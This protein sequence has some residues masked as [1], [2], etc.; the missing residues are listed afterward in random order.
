MHFPL[1]LL[2]LWSCGHISGGVGSPTEDHQVIGTAQPVVALTGQE[3]VLPCRLQPTLDA[4]R[5]TVEWSRPDLAPTYVH[6]LQDGRE[7]FGHKNPSYKFRTSLFAEELPNGNLSLRLSKATL[8]DQGLYKCFAPSLESHTLIQLLV[9]ATSQPVLTIIKSEDGQIVLMCEAKDLYPEPVMSWLD[10][11]GNF[12]SAGPTINSTHSDSCYNIQGN[13]TAPR[14]GPFTCRIQLQ[15]INYTLE[16]QI[17]LTES[18]FEPRRTEPVVIPVV[19]CC[20]VLILVVIGAVLLWYWKSQQTSNRSP[21]VTITMRERSN[22]I[23]EMEENQAELVYLVQENQNT[24]PV[25]DVVSEEEE[26]HGEQNA[27]GSAPDPTKP[28]LLIPLRR[29]KSLPI[30]ADLQ[31]SMSTLR[32]PS[33]RRCVSISMTAPIKISRRESNRNV[34]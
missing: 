6:I 8:A 16:E 4:A 18:Y 28:H 22:E 26:E 31:S 15:H 30:G 24:T 10:G 9:G 13:L 25:T 23:M 2:T 29:S 34:R 7:I 19:V 20:L 11:E 21:A 3:V 12:L 14:A 33:R 27:I 32:K 17:Q 5:M 1:C